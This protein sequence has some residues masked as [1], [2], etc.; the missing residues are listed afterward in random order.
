[1]WRS[2]CSVA[3]WPPRM[4]IEFHL[5]V[6]IFLFIDLC[7][8]EEVPRL[9]ASFVSLESFEYA[10]VSLFEFRKKQCRFATDVCPL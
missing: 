3:I 8:L 4:E 6:V 9:T 2:I 10:N 5:I 7:W 1:M